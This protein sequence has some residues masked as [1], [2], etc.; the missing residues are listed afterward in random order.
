MKTKLE[1]DGQK[2]AVELGNISDKVNTNASSFKSEEAG[3]PMPPPPN[4]SPLLELSTP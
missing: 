1:S 2:D 4:V 3:H